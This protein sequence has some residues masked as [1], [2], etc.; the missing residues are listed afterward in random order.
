MC[1]ALPG[2]L[3]HRVA[4]KYLLVTEVNAHRYWKTFRRWPFLTHDD[5]ALPGSL[6][7]LENLQ[8]WIAGQ[9]PLLNS[10]L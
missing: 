10:S 3:I 8:I 9:Q 6:C 7:L 1:C 5:H 2:P 4:S